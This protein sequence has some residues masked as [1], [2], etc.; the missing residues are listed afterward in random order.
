MDKAE[1][2][3]AGD[4]KSPGGS[5]RW[6]SQNQQ[7]PSFPATGSSWQVDLQLLEVGKWICGCGVCVRVCVSLQS[8]Y[9]VQKVLLVFVV[10]SSIVFHLV[11]AH[12]LWLQSTQKC[13]ACMDSNHQ[14]VH[15]TVRNNSYSV[16]PETHS[17]THTPSIRIMCIQY[18]CLLQWEIFSIIRISCSFFLYYS[19]QTLLFFLHP[20]S[21][22]AART[23]KCREHIPHR[24]CNHF[25][26]M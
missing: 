7:S 22:S 3:A 8:V 26:I 23:N 13:R 18:T 25:K 16:F 9:V 21:S 11:F 1:A 12:V 15:R 5:C 2:C 10:E 6:A 19:I 20:L 24:K 4:L 14:S 17:D